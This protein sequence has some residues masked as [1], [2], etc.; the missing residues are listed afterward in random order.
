MIAPQNVSGPT[1]HVGQSPSPIVDPAPLLFP[2]PPLWVDETLG[3]ATRRL[4]HEGH[5]DIVD[6]GRLA[7]L[8][9]TVAGARSMSADALRTGVCDAYAAIGRALT[10]LERLPIRFWNFIPD[11]GDPM[12]AGLDR[13]MVFNA[14]R[15]AGYTQWLGASKDFG[16]LLPTA[17]AVGV[18][19][20]DLVI[21]C[22]ASKERGAPVDNPR[23]TAAWRY[24]R[25]YG[26]ISPCFSR[27]TIANLNG[28]RL[29]LVGGTA[30]IVGE[31]SRHEGNVEAQL[32][33]TL[34]NL[35]AL[36]DA[37]APRPESGSA[38]DRLLDVR[39]YIA[40]PDQAAAIRETV[41]ARC[42]R[43]T[44]IELAIA[45]VCRPELLLEIEGVAEL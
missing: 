23:Q 38:L 17:S 8:G 35:E 6:S 13:Y 22:L 25:R 20:D 19:S 2:R 21:H 26:P 4:D 5:V 15:F 34:R 28:T 18:V 10:A 7:L 3:T 1:M 33:E 43:A 11:P 44:R 16:R 41:I 32:D 27:A 42:A 24:S 9:T 31:D 45:R 36:I 12:G 29:L 14:G 30:S 37:A 39:V 40:R